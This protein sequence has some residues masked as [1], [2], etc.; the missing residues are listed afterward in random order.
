MGEHIVLLTGAVM[1]WVNIIDNF[2]KT[3]YYSFL[4]FYSYIRNKNWN[5]YVQIQQNKIRQKNDQ[6]MKHPI[7]KQLEDQVIATLVACQQKKTVLM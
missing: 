5:E 7:R 2:I 3:E 4:C 1:R 6:I